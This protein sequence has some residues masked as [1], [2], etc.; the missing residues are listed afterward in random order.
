MDRIDKEIQKLSSREKVWVKSILEKIKN[1]DFSGLDLKRL[2]GKSDIFRV[3]KGNI[4]I[5]YRKVNDS[6]FVLT[7]ERR[8]ESTYKNL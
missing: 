2:K 8:N 3:R 5:I 6:V 4:R 7:I 1:N